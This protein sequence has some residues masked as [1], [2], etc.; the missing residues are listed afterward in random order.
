MTS[1]KPRCGHAVTRCDE[2]DNTIA[3]S[4][5]RQ[6][7]ACPK[8]PDAGHHPDTCRKYAPCRT[9]P[10]TTTVGQTADANQADERARKIL[11]GITDAAPVTDALTALEDLAGRVLKALDKVGQLVENLEAARY[12]AATGEQIRGEIQLLLQLMSRGESILSKILAH[13]LDARRVRIDE[14]RA[15]FVI[16]AFTQTLNHPDL[17]LPAD[18]QKRAREIL[19]D[20]LRGRIAR[21]GS[22]GSPGVVGGPG[23]PALAVPSKHSLTVSA[24]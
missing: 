21:P 2:C 10:G 22:L 18:T 6:G 8:H 3:P 24:C 9:H 1:N 12:E 16:T 5:I 4:R 7:L 23:R 20:T 14:A 19:T 13:D 17:A 11:A 15:T